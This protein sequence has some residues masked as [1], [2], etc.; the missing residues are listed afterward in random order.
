MFKYYRLPLLDAQ[1]RLALE[2]RIE[3]AQLAREVRPGVFRVLP[4]KVPAFLSATREFGEA[5]EVTPC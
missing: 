3:P 4:E 5:V 2:F 1:R